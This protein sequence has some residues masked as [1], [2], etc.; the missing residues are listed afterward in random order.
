MGR[1]RHHV[2]IDDASLSPIRSPQNVTTN[3]LLLPIPP[4][5]KGKP[6]KPPI[7]NLKPPRQRLDK[8]VYE[9][10]EVNTDVNPEVNPEP[11]PLTKFSI[12][13]NKFVFGYAILPT[14]VLLFLI[15]DDQSENV[16]SSVAYT[17]IYQEKDWMIEKLPNEI[18]LDIQEKYK[19]TYKP[20]H[21]LA[22]VK[23]ESEK[24]LAP[25]IYYLISYRSHSHQMEIQCD[26]NQCLI[27][28]KE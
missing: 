15:D 28:Y 3:Q 19:P 11:P 27:S 23:L 14:S 6:P 17:L 1:N 21:K 25:E 2:D 7:K 10:L 24:M 16:S 5:K 18:L 22:H 9:N 12:F 4:V 8:S 26:K 20:I 13:Q